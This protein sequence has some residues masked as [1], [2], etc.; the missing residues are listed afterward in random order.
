MSRVPSKPSFAF[1]ADQVWAA[2]AAAQRINGRYIK[3]DE[4]K[5]DTADRPNRA[6]ATEL[7]TTPDLITN[8]DREQ[9]RRIREHF[10][11]LTFRLLQGKPLNEFLSNALAI[12]DKSVIT[13]SYDIAIMASL[14]ATYERDMKRQL[15]DE[16]LAQAAGGYLAP[17]GAKVEAEVRVLRSN[18]SQQYGIFWITGITKT[19]CPVFFSHRQGHDAG[20][21]LTVQ[22]TVKAH[23]DNLT[24]L[25]RVKIL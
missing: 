21:W 18:F 2:V 5:P 10:Q 1:I 25:N 19:D 23:R 22:G 12:A 13:S 4:I 24:Q 14:P 20:T 8:E 7:L 17:V 11:A 16:K 3:A 6:I 15:D 9:G